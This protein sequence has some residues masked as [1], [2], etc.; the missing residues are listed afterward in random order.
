MATTRHPPITEDEQARIRELHGQGLTRNEIARALGRGQRTVSRHAA[1]MGL[2]FKRELTAAA[3][4]AK[5]IDARAKRAQ[6]A[7]DL[8]D[9]AERLRQRIHETYKVWRILNDGELA[10]GTLDL[11]DARD[12]RDLMVAVNT[13]VGAS[14]RLEEFDADTGI[15]GAKSMLNA[16]AKGLGAAYDELNQTTPDD[17]A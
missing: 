14:L 13:A 8:L 4:E 15:A 1:L 12:Q 17:G 10:T 2:D 3:V 6:L 11:P 7:L 5:V 9:D 16:L